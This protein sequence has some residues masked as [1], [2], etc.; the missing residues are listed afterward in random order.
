MPAYYKFSKESNDDIG[1][2]AETFFNE[3][4]CVLIKVPDEPTFSK[5]LYFVESQR[6]IGKNQ[7]EG[8]IGN[9]PLPLDFEMITDLFDEIS[10]KRF[11]ELTGE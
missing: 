3:A 10:E 8:V 4:G 7:Y 2:F 6:K 1:L 5:R 11:N 9:I